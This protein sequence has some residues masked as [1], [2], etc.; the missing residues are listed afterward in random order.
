MQHHGASVILDGCAVDRDSCISVLTICPI[1]IFILLQVLNAPI[2]C[3][4]ILDLAMV[5]LKNKQESIVATIFQF[6]ETRILHNG[7]F[8]FFLGVVLSKKHL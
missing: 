1:H 8:S 3:A 2:T 4:N 5:S 7:I 6:N